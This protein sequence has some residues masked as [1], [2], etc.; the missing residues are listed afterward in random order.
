MTVVASTHASRTTGC[1]LPAGPGGALGALEG[2]S[3][4]IVLGLVGFSVFT[5]VK[6]GKGLP[7]GKSFIVFLLPPQKLCHLDVS[8]RPTSFQSL[9][10]GLLV[11]NL[12]E[13]PPW[14][15]LL[16]FWARRKGLDSSL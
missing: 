11:R 3:Y 7:A 5:K 8:V 12:T 2:I 13:E 16:G 6:T 1:G 9:P 10:E 15:A 4:L 14:Q